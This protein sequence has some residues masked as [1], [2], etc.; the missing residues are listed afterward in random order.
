MGTVGNKFNKNFKSEKIT[1]DQLLSR[2][3]KND[4]PNGLDLSGRDLSGIILTPRALT[5]IRKKKRLKNRPVW[6]SENGGINLEGVNLSW[7]K[8]TRADLTEACLRNA[9]LR[10]AKVEHVDLIDADLSNSILWDANFDSATLD[11]T[12]L[13]GANIFGA[14]FTNSTI[15]KENIGDLIVQD[16]PDYSLPDGMTMLPERNRFWQASK[17]YRQL[18]AT[19]DS[20]GLYDNASWAYRNAR[21]AEKH[22]AAYHLLEAWKV[23]QWKVTIRNFRKFVS[24]T[25]VEYLSDYGE[26]PKHVLVSILVVWLGFAVIYGLLSGVTDIMTDLV[27]RH[28]IDLLAFSLGTMTTIEAVGLSAN[29]TLAMRFLMPLETLFAIALTGLFGYVLGNRINRI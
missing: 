4:G 14:R 20:N 18:K 9:D 2:I 13:Y 22:L 27:T 28:P 5:A 21:R 12:K 26:S 6:Q 23:G 15:S 1:V 11:G 24:D 8:L 16:L 7:A 17:I 29:N 25:F 19:F 10:G 3:I